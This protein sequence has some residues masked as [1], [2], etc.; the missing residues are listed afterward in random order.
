MTTRFTPCINEYVSLPVTIQAIQLTWDL[1]IVSLV[2]YWPE[3]KIHIMADVALNKRRCFIKTLEGEM[4]GQV[5]DWIIKGTIGEFYFCKDEVF[6]K[7]YCK[8]QS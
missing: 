5:G 1:D 4:E 8:H 2:K 6:Q 3:I 7:K